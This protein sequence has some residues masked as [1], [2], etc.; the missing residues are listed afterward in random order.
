[1]VTRYIRVTLS[2]SLIIATICLCVV[3]LMPPSPLPDDAPVPEFS[4]VRAMRHIEAISHKPH[5]IGSPELAVVRDYIIAQLRTIG[6]EPSAQHTLATRQTRADV[7]SLQP[8]EI[9]LVAVST[10]LPSFPGI[11]TAP[12]GLTIS[13]PDYGLGIPTDFTAVRTRIFLPVVR[14]TNE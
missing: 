5:P 1:M 6:L 7:L 13:P 14:R 10:G 11:V 3:H 8:V 4:A 12:P 9:R 2:L